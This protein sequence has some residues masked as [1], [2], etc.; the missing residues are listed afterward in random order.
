MLNRQA[1]R[2]QECIFLKLLRIVFIGFF[3]LAIMASWRF[4]CLYKPSF[5]SHVS[6]PNIEIY[7]QAKRQMDALRYEIT[8]AL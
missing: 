4:I 3:P 2:T 5:E 8:W 7:Q 6:K 1:Q